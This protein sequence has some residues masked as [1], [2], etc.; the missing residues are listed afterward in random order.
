MAF[1]NSTEIS[2]KTREGE[3]RVET[4]PQTGSK[5]FT[6]INFILNSFRKEFITLKR[7]SSFIAHVCFL[8]NT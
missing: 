7:K 4:S 5:Y 6:N 8:H 1:V 2:E 3:P